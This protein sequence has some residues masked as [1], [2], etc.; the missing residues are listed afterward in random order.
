MRSHFIVYV[1]DQGKSRDFYAAVLSMEPMLDVPGMT[2]FQLNSESVLGLM[3]ESG[4]KRLLGDSIEDPA[5][6]SGIP[7]SEL[8][9]HVEDPEATL[10]KA[11]ENGAKLLS[12]VQK[13]DWNHEAGYALDPDGHVVAFAKEIN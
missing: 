9:L 12:P 6:A 13:R 5:T 2:E 11:V 3:P 4:I 7:R 1:R 10:K 8:Y